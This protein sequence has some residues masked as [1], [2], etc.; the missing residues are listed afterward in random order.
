[1]HPSG[2]ESRALE[3]VSQTK[4]IKGEQSYEKEPVSF[5]SRNLFVV[6]TDASR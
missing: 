1:M 4:F 6:R 3:T 2:L 5:C